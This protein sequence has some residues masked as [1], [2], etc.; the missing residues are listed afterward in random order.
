MEVRGTGKGRGRRQAAHSALRS[1]CRQYLHYMR[2]MTSSPASR[3]DTQKRINSLVCVCHSMRIVVRV[4]AT[5][6]NWQNEGRRGQRASCRPSTALSASGSPWASL[7]LSSLHHCRRARP[8]QHHKMAD[9]GFFKG[10]SADQDRRFSDKELKLLKT[11]KFPPEFDKK[12]DMRKVNLSVIRPWIVKKV[13]ELVGFED[14]VVVEYAMG[15]LEDDSQPT[16]DPRKMQ[17]NLTGFL[18]SSTPAFMSALWNLLLEAQESPAGVPR[19]FVEE[20]KEEMRQARAGD[21]RAFEER[22]RRARLDEIRTNEREARGGGRGRGRGRGRG[23]SRFDDDRGHGDRTRDSGWGMR[24]GVRASR[25]LQP[26]HAESRTEA[27]R[28]S[29]FSTSSLSTTAQTS[30][31]FSP[32]LPFS[33]SHTP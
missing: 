3:P 23:G 16:P 13:V 7:R 24:G 25:L 9:A 17:I 27:W 31:S 29:T 32:Q 14:E 4:D 18:T 12:V 15:L 26:I 1:Y 20:K 8:G 21:T 6:C 22:D 10:T 11:M 28:T 19:T 5:R 30:F 2:Q 33:L